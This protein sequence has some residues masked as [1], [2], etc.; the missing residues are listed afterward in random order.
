MCGYWCSHPCWQVWRSEVKI[1]YVLPHLSLHFNFFLRQ[2]PKLT[3]LA[4]LAI[5]QSLEPSCLCLP[6][7]EAQVCPVFNVG[8]GDANSDLHACMAVPLPTVS[9]PQ[10][11]PNV[12]GVFWWSWVVLLGDSPTPLISLYWILN[13]L[14]F[15]L[16]LYL[17]P[18]SC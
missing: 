15:G 5:C 1:C 6:M 7:L 8:S 14:P 4:S 16:H 12:L 18:Q 3:I 2:G 9:I 10:I 13:L 17:V 11:S